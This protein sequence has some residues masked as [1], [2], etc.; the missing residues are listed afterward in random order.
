MKPPYGAQASATMFQQSSVFCQTVE[1]AQFTIADLC[2]D[3]D[4]LGL[5][6][7][8]GPCDSRSID[9]VDFAA[10]ERLDAVSAGTLVIIAG[11]EQPPPYRIDVALRQ[12]SARSLAGI[13]FTSN[14]DL[15]ETAVSLASRGSVP[16]FAAPGA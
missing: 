11:D 5:L 10:I 2:A 13:I 12:A 7:R 9:R 1:M 6:Q 15:A 16:V 8:A 14:L 3:A 4:R